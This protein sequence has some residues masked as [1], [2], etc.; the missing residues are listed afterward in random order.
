MPG[1]GARAT[2]RVST[3]TAV[4]TRLTSPY[5]D[6]RA[7]QQ[8]GAIAQTLNR[9]GKRSGR[10][11]PRTEAR[12]RS[13]RSDRRVRVHRPGEMTARSELTL[14]EASRRLGVSKMTVLRLIGDCAIVA[15]QVCTGP[16]RVCPRI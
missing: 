6:S 16:R 10:G 4:T 13:Y 15:R 8:D 11:N 7:M 3:T 1:S 9:L 5:V 12:V 14:E 2:A